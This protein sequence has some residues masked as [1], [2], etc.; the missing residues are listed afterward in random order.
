MLLGS[1][2]AGVGRVELEDAKEGIGIPVGTVPGMDEEHDPS[3][4]GSKPPTATNSYQQATNSVPNIVTSPI[5]EVS[6]KSQRA[7]KFKWGLSIELADGYISG[8]LV[9]YSRW[10]SGAARPALR[11]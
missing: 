1:H 5:H 3:E 6:V 7:I 4:A 9:R 10:H 2:G 8:D 11:I